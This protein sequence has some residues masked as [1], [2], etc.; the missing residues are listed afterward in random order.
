[1]PTGPRYIGARTWRSASGS[2]VVVAWQALGRE[3]DDLVED[4]AGA[5]A[6]D[7][8]EVAQA[9]LVRHGRRRL[10]VVDR[11]RRADDQR[12]RRLAEDRRQPRHRH[13]LGGDQVVEHAARPDRRELVHV[14]DEQDVRARARRRRAAA[15]PAAATASRPRRR[16]ACRSRR[17]GCDA[18]RPKPSPGTYSSSRW[19]VVASAPVSSASRRAAFPVGAHSRTDFCWSAADRPARASTPSCRRRGRPSAPRA[20]CAAPG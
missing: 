16:S 8:E 6:L 9:V 2:S 3:R 4:G 20:G 10:A 11:V 15:R 17:S 18:S 7:Q 14:A 5:G 13:R 12:S 19:I 1:M